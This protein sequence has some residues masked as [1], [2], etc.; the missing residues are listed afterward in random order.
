MSRL[1]AQFSLAAAFFLATSTG[2]LAQPAAPSATVELPP[3]LVEESIS[4]VP[5]L[6][7]DAGNLEFLS[8]CSS[9]VTR[10]L[11]EG[12]LR[13][14]QHVRALVPEGFLL[15]MDVPTIFVL[16]SQEI[17]QTV[18]AEI[19]RELQGAKS[20]AAAIA[21]SMRLADRDMHASIA[22]IDE[23]LFSAE[24]MSI[25][26]SHV[27][28]LLRHRI[29]ELPGWVV[30]GVE[31][32]LRSID[33]IQP[34][35]TLLPLRWLDSQS[36]DALSSDASAPRA[37]LPAAEL[38]ATGAAHAG[39]S[40]HPRR[41]A[42]RLAQQE[43]FFRWALTT[44]ATRE[45]YWKLA[46]RSAEGPVT[47]ELFESF[48]GFDY[49][50]LRDRLS[51]H[52][53]VATR[54]TQRID[55]G[56]LP[57]LPEFKIERATP[58]QIARLRGEW[59][60]LA[61]T[62]VQRRLP[63]AREPYLAQAR[64]TLRRAYDSGDRD[65][66]LLATLGLCEVDAGNDDAA[67]A[68][69]DPATAA[70][71]IRPRAYSEVARLRFAPLRER[72]ASGQSLS[73][74]ELAPVITPLRQSLRQSPPLAETYALLAEAWA[75]CDL[76]PTA[77]EFAELEAGARL[78]ARYPEHALPLARAF[79]RHDKPAAALH[80]LDLCAREV[81]DTTTAAAIARL[82]ATLTANKE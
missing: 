43:L 7:I 78:F 21:P 11:A 10:D 18:S 55:L 72:I 3:I 50:E 73:F 26:P 2:S 6:Y 30:D 71:V 17:R 28:Y 54:R 40:R 23:T 56:D 12:W 49:S 37:L 35:V 52:L 63:A 15:R 24:N 20:G 47:E 67:R 1:A 62:H 25:S 60:R 19:Q 74:T 82:R 64:R 13:G 76:S 48:F 51:D 39:E 66:R 22:Y 31:R 75:A 77:E 14:M 53:P 36:S 44:P 38:F 69:L 80:T 61:V 8:R 27:Q 59:E 42:T 58:N 68:F 41:R 29:P 79:A 46:T 57:P 70:G 45:A 9:S 32:T 81:A 65:P 33:H 5:W 4:S 34:A 16:Y